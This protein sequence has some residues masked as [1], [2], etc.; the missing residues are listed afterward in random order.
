MLYHASW[1]VGLM[2]LSIETGCA[3]RESALTWNVKFYFSHLQLGLS[4]ERNL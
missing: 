2:N 3:K 1:I 4:Q